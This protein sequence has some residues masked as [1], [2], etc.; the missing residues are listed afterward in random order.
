MIAPI[1]LLVVSLRAAPPVHIADAASN[2]IS[3]AMG[4][5]RATDVRAEG[6]IVEGCRR[7]AAFATLVQELQESDWIVFVQSG[8]C[9]VDGIA[10]CLLHV[11]AGMTTASTCASW[12]RRATSWTHRQSRR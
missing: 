4:Q 11:W 9:E 6:L 1:L 5:V 12:S 10:G 7:S 8:S 2:E 3:A